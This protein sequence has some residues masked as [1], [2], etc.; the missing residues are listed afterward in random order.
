MLEIPG[1]GISMKPYANRM[2]LAVTCFGNKWIQWRPYVGALAVPPISILTIVNYIIPIIQKLFDSRGSRVFYKVTSVFK[3][4][5][6]LFHSFNHRH[7]NSIHVGLHAFF[8]VHTT[9][10]FRTPNVGASQHRESSAWRGRPNNVKVVAGI[11]S[12]IPCENV[13]YNSRWVFVTQIQTH[14][15]IPHLC[16]NLTH[17][18][19]ARKQIQ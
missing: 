3:I 2:A 11:N 7:T 5:Y 18:M 8:G 19:G 10:L 4:S 12:V 9:S 14:N 13:S 16:G 15:F 17:R 6:Y 1:W